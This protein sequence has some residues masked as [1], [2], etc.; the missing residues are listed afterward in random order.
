MISFFI[1]LLDQL[2]INRSLIQFKILRDNFQM[3]FALGSCYDYELIHLVC[4][5]HK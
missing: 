1:N 5:Y 4:I 2:K 3:R